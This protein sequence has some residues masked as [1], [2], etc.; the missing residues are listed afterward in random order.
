[1]P[2]FRGRLTAGFT[3]VT[4][5]TWLLLTMLPST[6]AERT[7]RVSRATS[8]SRSIASPTAGWSH[9]VALGRRSPKS[10][11]FVDE[12]TVIVGNYWGELIK[13]DLETE[14]V[15]RRTVAFNGISSVCMQGRDIIASSYDG[16][17]YL[18]DP[19]DLSVVGTLRAM[20]QRVSVP[21]LVHV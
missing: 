3:T 9:S 5:V 1:M 18:V 14:R 10:M 4:S 19:A 17:L 6:R 15:T 7:W 13:F 8:H 11:C 12:T 20:I 16:A 21:E 2:S